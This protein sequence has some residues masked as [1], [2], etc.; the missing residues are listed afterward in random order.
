M[1]TEKAVTKEYLVFGA[2]EE[3]ADGSE[4]KTGPAFRA[5]GLVFWSR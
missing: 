1:I 2:R 4:V 3:A 5:Q